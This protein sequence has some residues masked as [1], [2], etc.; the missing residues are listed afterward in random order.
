MT[1]NFFQSKIAKFQQLP[2][3]TSIGRSA[4]QEITIKTVSVQAIQ[5]EHLVVMSKRAS[6]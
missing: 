4:K 2:V 1:P 6:P 5:K 3:S